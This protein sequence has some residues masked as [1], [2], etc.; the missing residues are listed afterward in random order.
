[1][2]APTPLRMLAYALPL[3]VLQFALIG[4]M[5]GVFA[6]MPVTLGSL[7]FDVVFFYGGCIAERN[8][9]LGANTED[10]VVALM[11]KHRRW[12]YA[13]LAAHSAYNISYAVWYQQAHGGAELNP[14]SN[15]VFLGTCLF[16]GSWLF[17]SLMPFAL[18]DLFRN[19]FHRTGKWSQRLAG[20]SY[21]AYIVHPFFVCTATGVF[22]VAYEAMTGR[23]I[24]FEE[25]RTDSETVLVSD[26]W[27]WGGWAACTLA[28]VTQTF[29]FSCWFRELC[30][31]A[32]RIL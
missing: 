22:V 8:K 5:G 9:W 6:Y 21:T 15:Y 31:K 29:L 28:S 10:G 23:Q 14:V 16:L 32:K 17:I 11:D 18:L 19:H 13:I 1:M 2:S 27:L 25:G 12:I 26:A 3:N 24:V 30:P 4:P 7:P 20:A